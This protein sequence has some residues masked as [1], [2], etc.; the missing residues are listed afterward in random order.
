MARGKVKK[1]LAA[2]S[3]YTEGEG[4]ELTSSSHAPDKGCSFQPGIGSQPGFGSQ[5]ARLL[6]IQKAM[7]LTSKG[8]V[9]SSK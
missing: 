1:H 2:K 9:V 8:K 4:K 7:P 5:P 6:K 3:M